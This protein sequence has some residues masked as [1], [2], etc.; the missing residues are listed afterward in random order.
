MGQRAVCWVL[1]T[2]ITPL[3][4]LLLEWVDHH[5]VM[6]RRAHIKG[7]LTCDGNCTFLVCLLSFSSV[8]VALDD[9][10]FVLLVVAGVLSTMDGQPV[11]YRKVQDL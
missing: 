5:H 10:P 11:F 8:G 4:W 3:V 7:K 6:P 1:A 2:W 9:F